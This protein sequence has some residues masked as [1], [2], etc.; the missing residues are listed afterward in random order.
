MRKKF[1]KI[2]LPGH[3]PAKSRPDHDLNRLWPGYAR[4]TAGKWKNW[5]GRLSFVLKDLPL[6]YKHDIWIPGGQ[7]TRKTCKFCDVRKFQNLIEISTLVE[8][9][10]RSEISTESENWRSE[11]FK[12]GFR[13]FISCLDRFLMPDESYSP[14]GP[15]FWLNVVNL[16]ETF[17]GDFFLS[18]LEKTLNREISLTRK[19]RRINF[20]RKKWKS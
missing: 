5:V 7:L 4:I 11:L 14:L 15:N 10:T 18:F 12:S 13:I 9:S 6:Q 20:V 1:Q 16:G 8:Y 19:I 2:L 3:L 17:F